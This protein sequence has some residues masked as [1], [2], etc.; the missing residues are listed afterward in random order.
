MFRVLLT[1]LVG[2]PMLMPPGMCLC[3]FLPC[4]RASAAGSGQT[5]AGE[6]AASPGVESAPS[7]GCRNQ[8]GNSEQAKQ[9]PGKPGGWENLPAG[10][11]CPVPLPGGHAPGCP[12]ACSS[13]AEKVALPGFQIQILAA[14]ALSFVGIAAV[15]DKA[16]V[17]AYGLPAH[18][19]SP[20]LFL[21]HCTLLI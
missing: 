6:A 20:P 19:H 3:Q 21:A 7:C 16:N 5:S 1:S 2:L 15:N 18:V 13:A 4:G 9:E 17:P 14:P 11:S 8:R 12:A 10:D